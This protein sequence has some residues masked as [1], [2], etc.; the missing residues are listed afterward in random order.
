ME[1][2]VIPEIKEVD[3]NSLPLSL[4]AIADPCEDKIRKYLKNAICFGAFT[5]G[6]IVAACVTNFNSADEIEIYNLVVT[7]DYQ[8]LGIGT[9]LLTFVIDEFK[10]RPVSKLVLGTGTFG[11]QLTFYQRLG[12]RIESVDKNFFTRNYA[13][14]IFENGMQHHDMLRLALCL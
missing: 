11:Y 3:G 7:P 10:R 9:I 13:A 8:G 2:L 1:D 6:Q 14:P 12:F 4:L 5:H